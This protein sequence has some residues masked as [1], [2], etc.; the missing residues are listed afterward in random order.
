MIA[1]IH[2]GEYRMK[3]R[4]ALIALTLSLLIVFVCSAIHPHDYF[5]WI[6][7]VFPAIIGVAV[8]GATCLILGWSSRQTIEED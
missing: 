5:T 8:L 3:D 6:L 2:A 7:E 4:T 1:P